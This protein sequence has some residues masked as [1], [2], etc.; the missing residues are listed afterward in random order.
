MKFYTAFAFVMVMGIAMT[1]NVYAQTTLPS[2]RYVVG[3]STSATHRI[4]DINDRVSVYT[5]F[6][7]ALVMLQGGGTLVVEAGTYV[8][9][10]S[11]VLPKAPFVLRGAGKNQTVLK[12]VDNASMP[13]MKIGLL[14]AETGTQ[15]TV[16]DLSLDG[17]RVAQT[18]TLNRETRTG[19]YCTGCTGV[20]VRDVDVFG[21][22]GYGFW[23]QPKTTLGVATPSS[24]VTMV[25]VSSYSNDY[26]GLYFKGTNQVSLTKVMSM[27]NGEDGFALSGVDTAT[28]DRCTTQYNG[29]HGV[30]VDMQTKSVTIN[31]L[32]SKSDG[33]GMSSLGVPY[34]GSTVFLK[35]AAGAP[36][37]TVTI[38]DSTLANPNMTAVY[39][40]AVNSL[41][42]SSSNLT[43]SSYCMKVSFVTGSVND[44]LC[45]AEKGVPPADVTVENLSV[46]NVRFFPVGSV[47]DP[48]PPMDLLVR[49]PTDPTDPS[50]PSTPVSPSPTPSPPSPEPTPSPSPSPVTPPVDPA[51]PTSGAGTT[52]MSILNVVIVGAVAIKALLM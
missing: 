23:F 7:N 35:G 33:H 48:P 34:G 9:T 31:K 25:D 18:A 47:Y 17:N 49:P 29:R 5:M 12:L 28:L 39:A 1:G 38:T 45:N 13:Q 41:T 27:G 3:T 46:S 50:T 4:A 32:T 10:D 26:D 24:G 44:I 42:V 8:L 22:R 43:G 16:Q 21:W 19:F 40:E 11:L 36:L 15:L 6:R 14:H 20:T 52:T 30:Y 2:T 37:E 51:A